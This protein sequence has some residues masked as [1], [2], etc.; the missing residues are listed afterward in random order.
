M[1]MEEIKRLIAELVVEEAYL[2]AMG[3]R[4][5]ALFEAVTA[6][7]KQQMPE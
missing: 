7:L 6:L 1:N 4:F 5:P 3:F 2:D